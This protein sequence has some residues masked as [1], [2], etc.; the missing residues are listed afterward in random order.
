[1]TALHEV[2]CPRNVPVSIPKHNIF[3]YFWT[4]LVCLFSSACRYKPE[5]FPGMKLSEL[6]MGTYRKVRTLV[7]EALCH[8]KDRIFP[9]IFFFFWKLVSM[10][11]F[12]TVMQGWVPS[13]VLMSNLSAMQAAKSWHGVKISGLFL[14]TMLWALILNVLKEQTCEGNR[15]FMILKSFKWCKTLD[16]YPSLWITCISKS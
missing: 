10:T 7:P 14:W 11:S 15:H 9:N 5:I 16:I 4:F 6:F 2:G 1:M 13:Y 12:M 3:P 8:C